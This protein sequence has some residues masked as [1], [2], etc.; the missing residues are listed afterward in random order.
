MAGSTR[1][2]RPQMID[3]E[4]TAE[5]SATQQIVQETPL[6]EEPETTAAR[7]LSLEAE[8]KELEGRIAVKKLEREV[9]RLR[10]EAAEGEENNVVEL[11]REALQDRHS[12]A[13]KRTRDKII[14]QEEQAFPIHKR[15]A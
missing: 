10:K 1:N 9:E 3:E 13:T 15:G 14:G 4:S 5:S 8:K 2:K 11:D 7:Q 12:N 6:Q